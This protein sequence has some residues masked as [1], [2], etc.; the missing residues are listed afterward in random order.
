[1][2]FDLINDMFVN[3]DAV[4]YNKDIQAAG[5]A[6]AELKLLRSPPRKVCLTR[7]PRAC[8]CRARAS[9]RST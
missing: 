8:R 5:L 9:W 4:D 1:M 7:T 6:D 3:Y 2:D